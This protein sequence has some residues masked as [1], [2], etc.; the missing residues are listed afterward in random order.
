MARSSPV[1]VWQA[2]SYHTD[3]D[4][5]TVPARE[6]ET[7]RRES[8]SGG[9]QAVG[10]GDALALYLV[11]DLAAMLALGTNKHPGPFGT[12][13]PITVVAG[14]GNHRGS[15]PVELAI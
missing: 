10:A 1:G 11:G 6:T 7:V 9:A 2:P 15:F 5:P 3:P 12:G 13:V 4:G 14:A 8:L